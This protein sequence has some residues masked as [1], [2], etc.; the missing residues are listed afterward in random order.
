[1]VE[2]GRMGSM[3]HPAPMVPMVEVTM[4]VKGAQPVVALAR[5]ACVE[6]EVQTVVP[7][8]RMVI[9]PAVI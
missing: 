2:M 1:M 9:E 7:V 8:S 5:R 4:V 3:V 6:S